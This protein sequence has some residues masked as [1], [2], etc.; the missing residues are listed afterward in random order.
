MYHYIIIYYYVLFMILNTLK[1]I[2]IIF[3]SFPHSSFHLSTQAIFSRTL[4]FLTFVYHSQSVVPK[5]D[6]SVF[7]YLIFPFSSF[8]LLD[9]ISLD[10]T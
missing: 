8:T 5:V 9:F 4:I 7:V 3:F 6:T 2:F 10:F 1:V